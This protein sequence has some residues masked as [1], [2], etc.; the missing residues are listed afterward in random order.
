MNVNIPEQEKVIA[1]YGE[2]AQSMIHMEEC[3]ELIQA[4]SKM[5]R[6][7]R[8]CLAGADVDDSEAY[9][10]LVEEMA[11][12]LICMEQ[13]REIYGIS[14]SEIQM[15]IDK[16]AARQEARLYDAD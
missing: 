6:L 7:K 12:V 9:Y 14:L 8:A 3:A 5:R 15:M 16:K 2:E 10:N 1:H 13:L 4:I 11:D